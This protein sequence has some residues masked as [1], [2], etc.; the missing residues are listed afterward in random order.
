[1]KTMAE[2]GAIPHRAGC[3][4]A[5][6]HASIVTKVAS[7]SEAHSLPAGALVGDLH[8]GLTF[9]DVVAAELEAR[10]VEGWREVQ[11]PGGEIWTVILLDS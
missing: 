4:P 2:T 3:A 5:L 6:D 11:G 1:M 9:T 10:S 7:V 8:G